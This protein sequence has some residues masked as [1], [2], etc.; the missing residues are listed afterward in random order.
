M[1]IRD[2]VRTGRLAERLW[3]PP[4]ANLRAISTSARVV[5][6]PRGVQQ[7]RHQVVRGRRRR[8]DRAHPELP[9]PQ[10]TLIVVGVGETHHLDATVT[11]GGDGREGQTTQLP[12]HQCHP[13]QP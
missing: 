10:L 5:A 6:G 4:A 7:R 11:K 8:D 2:R 3:D 13:A 9:Q 1:C 12:G